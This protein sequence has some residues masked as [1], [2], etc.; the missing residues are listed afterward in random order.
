MEIPCLILNVES[1]GILLGSRLERKNLAFRRLPTCG[2]MDAAVNACSL[3][4][5]TCVKRKAS[6]LYFL[7][8]LQVLIISGYFWLFD[9]HDLDV[10]DCT[11][12]KRQLSQAVTRR[13]RRSTNEIYTFCHFVSHVGIFSQ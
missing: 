1:V 7:L 11:L 12:D 13:I 10:H 5:L 3:P 2:A 6:I 4:K 8:L 9:C